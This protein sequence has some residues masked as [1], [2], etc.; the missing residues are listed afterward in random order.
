MK[1]FIKIKKEKKKKKT[2]KKKKHIIHEYWFSKQVIVNLSARTDLP[3]WCH[4]VKACGS[5]TLNKTKMLFCDLNLG[6]KSHQTW[7]IF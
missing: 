4:W 2:E 1:V 3:N 7:Q 6:L 5:K